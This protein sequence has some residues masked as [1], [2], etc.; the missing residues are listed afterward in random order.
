MDDMKIILFYQLHR[1]FSAELSECTYS[2]FFESVLCTLFIY[3]LPLIGKDLH[4]FIVFDD[5][6]G[7]MDL[8]VTDQK[9]LPNLRT[10][11]PLIV[12]YG[13]QFTLCE[14]D[15]P[16]VNFLLFPLESLYDAVVVTVTANVYVLPPPV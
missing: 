8:L 6:H 3:N 10:G 2:I 11:Q 5:R 14:N 1:F 7:N 16:V 12:S 15:V 4:P 13:V 9:R